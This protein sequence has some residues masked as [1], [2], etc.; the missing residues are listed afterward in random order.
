MPTHTHSWL[1]AKDDTM[2]AHVARSAKQPT[3]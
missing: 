3:I 1:L 2:A